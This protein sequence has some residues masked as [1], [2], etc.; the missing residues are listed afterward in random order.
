M[1]FKEERSFLSIDYD[2]ETPVKNFISS[3]EIFW[4]DEEA[5]AIVSL[6][7]EED[8]HNKQIE[9]CHRCFP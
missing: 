2:K 7:S 9:S 5:V 8:G 3:A 6:I 4:K 1:D